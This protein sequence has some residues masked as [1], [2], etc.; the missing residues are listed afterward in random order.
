MN[1][2]K[3][4]PGSNVKKILLKT[5]DKLGIPALLPDRHIRANYA[6]GKIYLNLKESGLMRM[7]F[8]NLYE[9]AKMEIFK[10]CLSP[11]MKVADVGSNRG[12]FALL[13]AKYVGSTGRVWA[14]E[15]DPDNFRWLRESVRENS[16]DHLEIHRLALW[17]KNERL[18]LFRGRKSGWSSLKPG[19]ESMDEATSVRAR[20]LDDFVSDREIEGLDFMKIDVEGAEEEVLSGASRVLDTWK[21][22]LS[23]DLHEGVDREALHDLLV[24]RGYRISMVSTSWYT[25]KTIEVSPASRHEFI[26]GDGNEILA[27][28]T[29]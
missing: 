25:V 11:G 14:F 20:T 1:F 15:P 29:D 12:Y 9:L 2:A 27:F 16:Y 23:M 8:L 6:G 21:P 5:A 10:R 28:P 13:A 17:N 24:D 3:F 18:P 7:R 22:L 26:E 19:E 4:R